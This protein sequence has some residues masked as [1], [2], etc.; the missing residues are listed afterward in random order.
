MEGK[1][2]A[3]TVVSSTSDVGLIP[4]YV[5][6]TSL[7]GTWEPAESCTAEHLGDQF[8]RAIGE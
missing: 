2:S 4:A 1:R 8:G 7:L 6:V 5:A 3:G